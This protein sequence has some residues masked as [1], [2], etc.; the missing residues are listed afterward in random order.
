MVF[1]TIKRIE[2]DLGV[3]F[4]FQDLHA[5]LSSTSISIVSSGVSVSVS[6]T[7]PNVLRNWNGKSTFVHFSIPRLQHWCRPCDTRLSSIGPKTPIIH[8]DNVNLLPWV[9]IGACFIC[10]DVR[11]DRGLG[12]LGNIFSYIFNCHFT[13]NV[14]R[15][16]RWFVVDFELYTTCTEWFSDQLAYIANCLRNRQ[17][18][19]CLNWILGSKWKDV[20]VVGILKL[21]LN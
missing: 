17:I 4:I 12:S 8:P 21:E 2:V 13:F 9:F 15:V 7:C 1:A 3:W 6:T 10:Y 19:P 18:P 11:S 5:V 16:L 20:S 14:F